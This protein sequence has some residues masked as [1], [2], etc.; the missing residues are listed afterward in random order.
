MLTL[1]PSIKVY[2]ARG[3]TDMRKSFDS[4]AGLVRVVL[5]GDPLS[6]HLFVFCGRRRNLIKILYWDGSGFWLVAK[7]L[8]RG[9]FSWPDSEDGRPSVELRHDELTALLGGVDLHR[10][11]WRPWWRSGPRDATPS[12]AKP[13]D[14]TARHR[15]ASSH[16]PSA[17]EA[18]RRIP[19][20]AAI[21]LRG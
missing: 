2:L 8:A 11:T 15:C 19:S 7:R 14:A 9:T 1:G 17:S 13:N 5:A 12:A 10:A 16:D 6:G 21:G 20:P 18:S 4:L 3:T